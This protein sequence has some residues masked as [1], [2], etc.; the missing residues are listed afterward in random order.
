MDPAQTDDRISQVKNALQQVM[1]ATRAATAPGQKD[2]A[3]VCQELANVQVG[4]TA[5]PP[6]PAAT[7]T[8]A[9]LPFL[10]VLQF[11][12][13]PRQRIILILQRYLEEDSIQSDHNQGLPPC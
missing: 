9:P 2:L 4:A 3:Q 5:P 6:A 10:G 11:R 7:E 13:Q 1:A 8:P 12:H